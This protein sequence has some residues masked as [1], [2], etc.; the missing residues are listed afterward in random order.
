MAIIASIVFMVCCLSLILQDRVLP[1]LYRK[2]TVYYWQEMRG[3]SDFFIDV[4]Q[5]KVWY[6][7]GDL[8]FNLKTFDPIKKTIYG[9]TIY[10]FGPEFDLI[11]VTEA[12][13]AL[14]TT[15]GWRL[16]NG[17]VTL[18]EGKDQF[19]RTKSFE[20]KDL[21]ITETPK[22]FQEIEKEVDGLRLK[23]LY[24]YVE[25]TKKAGI[26]TKVH[27]VTLQYRLS[28]S[29]IPLVMTILAVPFAVRKRREGGMG[30]D[31]AVGLAVTFVYW[32]FYSL[33]L[34]MGRNGTL[35]PV[36]SAWLP[37][38]IFASLAAYLLSRRKTA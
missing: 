32:L 15:E 33:S 22:D 5:D 18:F 27:E 23:E 1:L 13:E 21:L 12:K 19:P 31:L 20:E 29:F 8:I 34:S 9:M 4:K 14:Y 10:T 6:R 30:A 2:R 36:I 7:S 16:L 25:K 11:Q 28:L 3:R 17:T 26:D 38:L 35:P 37:S 24:R